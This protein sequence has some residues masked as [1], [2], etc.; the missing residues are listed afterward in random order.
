MI[1]NKQ[2]LIRSLTSYFYSG[3]DCSDEEAEFQPPTGGCYIRCE[4]EAGGDGSVTIE[5]TYG[6]EDVDETL[7]SFDSEG[8]AIGTQRFDTITAISV[9]LEEGTDSVTVYPA[10]ETGDII[11]YTTYSESYVRINWKYTSSTSA[12]KVMMNVGGKQIEAE[13]EIRYNKNQNINLDDLL[14]IDGSWFK[15]DLIQEASRATKLAYLSNTG[16]VS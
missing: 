9:T 6:G 16:A 4:V 11:N 1:G 3:G 12:N 10:S 2:I 15:V 14:Y 13:I 8:A 7:T 5:G